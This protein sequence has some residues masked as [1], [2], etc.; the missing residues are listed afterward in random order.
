M[1]TTDRLAVLERRCRLLTVA[2]VACTVTVGAMVLV[3][4]SSPSERDVEVRKLTCREVKIVN[5]AGKTV[6]SLHGDESGGSLLLVNPANGQHLILETVALQIG[7]TG[8]RGEFHLAA[9]LTSDPETGGTLALC[10]AKS[11]RMKV[12]SGGK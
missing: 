11:E 2:S 6:A 12:L 5:A 3:G 7:T 4:A 10:G 8:P 9:S 1:N